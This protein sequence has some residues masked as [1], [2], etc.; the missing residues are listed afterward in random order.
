MQKEIFN[1]RSELETLR[2]AQLQRKEADV[3]KGESKASVVIN[4]SNAFLQDACASM[5]FCHFFNFR[6]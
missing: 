2:Q 5:R 3:Q 1:L 6:Y 4:R